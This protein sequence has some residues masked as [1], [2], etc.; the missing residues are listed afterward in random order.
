MANRFFSPDQQFADSTG[1]PYASGFL[2]FFASGTSTPLN[3]Y[4]DSA[5]TIPN[6]NPIV[7]DSAGRAGSV[8]LQNLPYK[9]VL[10]DA[11]SVQVWT[12]DPVWSSD[13][14]TLAQVQPFSGNPN[15]L[16]AG[17]AGTQGALPG[18]SMAWDYIN[19]IL[20]IATTTGNAATT[21]WTAVNTPV[22]SSF[23]PTPG[24]YLT[25][26]GDA[27]N[28]V[29]SGGNA[30]G[31]STVFYTPYMNNTVP[32]YNG[33]SFAS[34]LFVQPSLS[35]V[36]AH[37]ANTLYDVFIFNN[38]GVPTLVTGPAWAV[39]T[40]GSGARGTGAGTTQIQRISGVWVN[41]VQMTGRNGV[42]T[43]TINANL[44]TYLGTIWIDAAAG[45]VSC[46]GSYGQ[47][48]KWGVWNAYNRV[49]IMLRAGDSTASWTEAT[50]TIR[51]I[52][53]NTANSLGVMC[54]L[55]EEQQSIYCCS[56]STNVDA[57]SGIFGIGY[58]STVAFSGD[59]HIWNMGTFGQTF[60]MKMISRFDAPPVLGIQTV[61]ALVII[62]TPPVTLLGTEASTVI[63]AA[64]RG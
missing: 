31:N 4:S 34:T 13:F 29:I 11:N 5:L 48:R 21:V 55:A 45:Q 9:V 63:R 47:S 12:E 58:G 14:S 6:T 37:A 22:T 10:S 25:V 52:N 2:A 27:N 44:A 53:N 8:F 54:G 7:L 35:L 15:G 50:A 30:A 36:A 17:I 57:S 49:P 42:S 64:Y 61:T 43:F 24:G 39:S 16:L 59:E 19:N 40:S 26:T 3:T 60:P 56:R 1:L 28:P 32:I 20:Y 41:S 46:L 18:S 33:T 23:V 51:P 62:T 38:S